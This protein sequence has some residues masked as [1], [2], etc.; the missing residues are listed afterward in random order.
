MLVSQQKPGDPVV[1]KQGNPE[2]PLDEVPGRQNGD[3]G[4]KNTM[5]VTKIRA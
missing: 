3:E 2:A 4:E 5:Q 1:P